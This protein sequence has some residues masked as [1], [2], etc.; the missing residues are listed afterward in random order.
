MLQKF[1]KQ[2]VT[3]NAVEG[4]VEIDETGQKMFAFLLLQYK[5]IRLTIKWASDV[6]LPGKKPNCPFERMLL[7]IT[8][9]T[10]LWLSIATKNLLK[11]G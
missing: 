3:G 4:L 6:L 10:S 5:S 11:A 1:F 8:N 9:F 2:G 7:S